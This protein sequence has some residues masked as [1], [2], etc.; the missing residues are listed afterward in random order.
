MQSA[1]NSLQAARAELVQASPEKGGYRAR[2]HVPKKPST[3]PS[4]ASDTP[5]TDAPRGRRQIA[6]S[7]RNGV[8][9]DCEQAGNSRPFNV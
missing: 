1:L 9:Y 3:R 7:S 2:H 4:E 6:V 5:A 8:L